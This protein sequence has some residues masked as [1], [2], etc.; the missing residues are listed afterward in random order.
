MFQP[1]I[2]IVIPTW[3][4]GK[5]LEQCLKSLLCQKYP[6]EKFE[7]ILISRKK[8]DLKNKKIKAIRIR[9][10]INH[11]Q[12]RNIGVKQAKGEVIAFCDD[13][14]V[15]PRNWLAVGAKYFALQKADL[16]GG[17]ALPPS[18]TSFRHRLG[19]YLSGSRFCVGFAASRHRPVFPEKEA[20]EFDL[21][22]ANTFVDKKIFENIG[23]FCPT[24]VPCEENYFY[25]RLKNAGYKLLYCP[26]IACLHPPKPIF[27][28]WAKKIFF[29]ATGRGLLIARAPNTFHL[30]YFIPSLFIITLTSLIILST[31]DSIYQV[32]LL[33]LGL[34]YL[35]LTAINALYIYWRFEK[36]WRVL[37]YTPLAT[38]LIHWAY[39]LGFLCGLSRYLLGQK[40]AVKM[41]SK[42]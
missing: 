37:A 38:F 5:I 22:L 34:S 42:D 3:R 19:G 10:S 2:S 4:E 21:I 27:F 24:Q 35:L 28:P 12:A 18:K 36:D 8:I 20:N 25:S 7:I 41:P 30:Q 14:C 17:P 16:I 1:F 15:L 33:T 9:K 23:G 13:D 29:Y 26:K 31:R 6:S 39:G 40:Q 11:A 32:L